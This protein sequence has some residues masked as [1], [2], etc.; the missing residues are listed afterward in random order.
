MEKRNIVRF[1]LPCRRRSALRYYSLCLGMI[2][3]LIIAFSSKQHNDSVYDELNPSLTGL[4][5]GSGALNPLSSHEKSASCV[6]D[7][8]SS[9]NPLCGNKLRHLMKM[10]KWLDEEYACLMLVK[11]RIC[12]GTVPWKWDNTGRDSVRDKFVSWWLDHPGAPVGI[13]CA[14]HDDLASL[15]YGGRAGH[16]SHMPSYDD[17]EIPPPL[18]LGRTPIITKPR[19]Q[20]AVVISFVE[21]QLNKILALLTKHWSEFPPCDPNTLIQSADLIIFTENKMSEAIQRRILSAFSELSEAKTSCF[22]TKEPIFLHLDDVDPKLSHLEG[23]A[24]A[25]FSLFRLL[26]QNYET[27]MLTEPDIAPIRPNFLPALV[28]KSLAVNCRADG[29]WQFGSMP[30]AK[31]VD[32]GMLKQR[33]DFHMNGNAIYALGCPGFEDYKCR[34]QSFYLPE[35]ECPHVA[36]CS[37]HSKYEGGYDHAMYRFR[38]Q[39]E[40][41]DYSRLILP[42]FA[43]SDF[44]QNLGESIYNVT[45]VTTRSPSTYFVHSKS[46]YNSMAA[47]ILKEVTMNVLDMSPCDFGAQVSNERRPLLR[48]ELGKIYRRLRSGEYNK[49][50]V[51]GHLCKEQ[52]QRLFNIDHSKCKGSQPSLKSWQNRMPGKTYLWTMDLHGGPANCDTSI[53]TEAGGALHSEIIGMCEHYGLCVDRLKV[54]KY[55]DMREYDPSDKLKEQFRQAYQDDP[56]FKRVDA[57]ICHHPVANCELFLSFN[58]PIIIHAS[59]RL[60]F[61]RHDEGIN[62]RLDTGYNR[63]LGKKKW[64]QWI[65]TIQKL[66]KDKRNIIAANNLYDR[67]Y[68]KYFTGLEDVELLPSWC[69]DGVGVKFCE[70]DWESSAPKAWLPTRSEVVIVPYRANL[71]RTRYTMNVRKQVDHPIIREL[72][73]VKHQSVTVKLIME[74]YPDANP[75]NMLNHPAIIILPYQVSTINLIELYRLNIPTFCP[76]LSLL[77]KWC[78]EHDLMW[79][80]HYGWP[81]S[82]MNITNIPNPNGWK[83]QDKHSGEWEKMFDHWMHKSDF[84]QYEHITYFHS[85]E[86]FFSQ[87]Q[88]MS[89]NG[90]LEKINRQMVRVNN[91]LREDLVKRWMRVFNRI[92]R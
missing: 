89:R 26:E 30:L 36:G 8:A 5:R 80:V 58:K 12:V 74:L 57:F 69:G 55:D 92:R 71:D 81:E 51:I 77:K 44:I 68:I 91:E 38:V 39:P 65:S 90:E 15:E 23:A 24:Y 64:R 75:L 27:F 62:W 18:F 53:I 82:L 46:I 6:V 72:N 1:P 21:F 7:Q 34:V 79:E 43:Y 67:D 61:G 52:H 76:S 60:E 28:K 19:V 47:T 42:K 25:F 32:A 85:W 87:Y 88:I 40:N 59:T 84:Y 2:L 20:V 16:Q 86:H 50:D 70:G 11:Q 37:T 66:A 22:Q 56:E 31:D 45:S 63:E 33:V 54:M 49:D 13:S 29:V 17:L 48:E 35:G 10:H 41:Y 9:R 14:L 4:V 83:S 3:F 78:Q 73:Q